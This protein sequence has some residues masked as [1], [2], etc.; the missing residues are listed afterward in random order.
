[1]TEVFR[2]A[3]F[4]C[5]RGDLHLSKLSILSTLLC[6]KP[7]AVTHR[8]FRTVT[9]ATETWTRCT[10]FTAGSYARSSKDISSGSC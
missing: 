6:V 1:M 3:V 7:M 9:V 4:T 10:D 2:H 8:V 5:D